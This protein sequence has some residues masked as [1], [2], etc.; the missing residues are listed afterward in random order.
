VTLYSSKD[1]YATGTTIL[2]ATNTSDTYTGIYSSGFS[3]GSS[4]TIRAVITDKYNTGTTIQKSTTLQMAQRAVNIAKN[5]N[6]VAIGGFSSITSENQDGLFECNWDAK[7]TDNVNVAGAETIGGNLTVS[8][9]AT[10]GGTMIIGGKTVDMD[11]TGWVT[12]NDAIRYRKKNGFVIVTGQS[13]GAVMLSHGVYNVVGTLP[14]GMRPDFNMPFVFHCIGGAMPSQ[15][16][17][18]S[19]DGKI[20]LYSAESNRDYW[21]FSV[22]YPV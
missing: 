6:G 8:G 4:Y 13:S 5:G 17:Y 7:F 15:S 16:A 19:Y 20:Q 11:D 21:M 22:M 3:I 18:I 14:T 2:A 9:N 1:N 10:I 12:L